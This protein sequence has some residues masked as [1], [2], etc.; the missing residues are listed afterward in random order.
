MA[1]A[2]KARA[3]GVSASS[4]LDLKAE[5]AKKE[6]QFTRD[7]AAGKST[8]LVGGV[9]RPD[10]K[11][12]KWG[13]SNKGVNERAAR[14][15]ELEEIS[16][17]TLE[18]ARAA[19]ERKAQIYEKLAKGKSGGLNEKQY[20]TLLV[21][22]DSK[23]IDPYESDSDDVDESL[24]VPRSSEHDDDPIVEYEDEFGRARTGRRSE[25]P[26]HLLP[27]DQKEDVDDIDP[28][29][30][31][32]PVNHF[33]TY[34]PSEEKIQEIQASL[35]E[36]DNPLNIHYDA[37]QENRAKGAGFYQ[38]SGDEETRR[39]QMEELQ[40]VREETE[41]VR[42]ETGAMDVRPGEVEGL[43]T[44]EGR[45]GAVISQKSRAQ[46][47]RKREIEERRRLLEAKRRKKDP[48][49]N[50][51]GLSGNDETPSFS[52]PPGDN[53]EPERPPPKKK[54]VLEITQKSQDPF[55]A[56]EARVEPDTSKGKQPVRAVQDAD[57]FLA[58]LERDIMA[59]KS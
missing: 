42:Q 49:A 4:F 10:K 24:T 32:N 50:V 48:A 8:S 19:L 46:E 43:A 6:E 40:K 5:L 51:P 28:Y 23:P 1:P 39:K 11:P 58:S 37:S 35:L 9:K 59:K 27:S 25:I 44:T 16:R 47:K 55:A 29:V 31:Y 54:L 36:E 57:A 53:D 26:R 34:Q 7:K 30:I 41:K 20:E 12:T 3:A 38:F 56:L 45:G 22:F 17:P 21:D 15:V 33:P 52:M 18:A 2:N 13:T 14:D